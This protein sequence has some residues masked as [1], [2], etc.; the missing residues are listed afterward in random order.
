VSRF[1]T[2]RP[3][4]Q[5]DAV[6]G[7]V[8][9]IQSV[10]AGLA[11]GLLAG[12]NPLAGLYAYLVGPAAGAL[13]TS[14]AFMAIQ[15]TGAMAVV[16]ADV[17]E[18][19]T[20]L[21]PE[22]AL[23]TL[24]VVTGALMLVA[25]VL[26]LGFVMR[27]VSNAV[28]V[29]F[30]NAVGVNIVLGQLAD[31][32]GYAADGPNR[33]ARAIGTFLSPAQLHLPSLFVGLLT[34]AL[35]VLIGRTR[36]GAMGL[37][38]AVGV[39]SAIPVALGWSGV[40]TIDDLGVAT[41]S[42]PLP[43]VPDPSLV[44]ALLLPAIA[45]AFVGLIQ[46]ASISASF[47]NPDGR[48]PDTSRDF[49][50]QG[51]ANVAAG[52]FQG[53]PVGGSLSATAILKHA[54]AASR[55]ALLLTS[56]VMIVVIVVFGDVVGGLAMPSLAGLLIVVGVRT[57]KPA[58]LWSVWRTGLIQ[59]V[60]VTTTFVLTLAIPMQY[61]VLVGVGLSII[62][63]VVRQSNQV[64]MKR[65][66]LDEQGHATESDPPARLPAGEVVVLQPYG[67]LF[68]AAAPVLE[69]LLPTPDAT[70]RG[71]VVIIRVRGRVELGV[72]FLALL[73][74]YA[75]SLAAVDSKLVIVS[76]SERVEEQL[77]VAGITALIGPENIYAG[78]ERVGAALRRAHADAAAWVRSRVAPSGEGEGETDGRR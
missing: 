43:V 48:Y 53:M 6:A 75:A 30:I 32:T 12:V 5:R 13:A 39:A 2:I 38:I 56:V 62:L 1:A 76:T 74:R 37:V 17:P 21:D 24:A 67:S 69:T 55:L 29:G 72:T 36:L 4:L 23:F 60:V 7:L 65:W 40:A 49:A 51:V 25:G 58:D 77:R 52:L 44:P 18:V 31:L 59:K 26:R 64:T 54:G 61:A 8:L 9:G 34:I 14:S 63:H 78:D 20:A 45:L 68:F 33:I 46:G 10:P 19:H 22:R 3:A 57:V 15:G 28:M 11:N 47:P 50:G 16:I 70:S 42:L 35:I 41:G 27:F 66:E 73:R 71:S